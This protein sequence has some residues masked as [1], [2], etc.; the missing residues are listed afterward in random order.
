MTCPWLMKTATASGSTIALVNLRMFW[1][2]HLKTIWP[3]ELS[4]AAM[5]SRRASLRMP[6]ETLLR[7]VHPRECDHHCRTAAIKRIILRPGGSRP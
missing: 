3:F 1:S 7:C 2:G 5:N 4:G 6:I